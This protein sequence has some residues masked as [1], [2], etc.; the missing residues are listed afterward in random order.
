M[1]KLL[2]FLIFLVSPAYAL[3]ITG[4]TNPMCSNAL[5]THIDVVLTTKEFGVN[6]YT[7]GVDDPMPYGQQ[8]WKDLQAGKYGK[9][10]PYVAPK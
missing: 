8:L 4:V 3:T 7:A 10:A 5:C 9:P 6:P 2:F 1:K